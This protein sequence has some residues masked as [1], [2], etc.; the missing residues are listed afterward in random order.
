MSFKLCKYFSGDDSIE[1][2]KQLR[3][4]Q[5]KCGDYPKP[6]YFLDGF[7]YHYRPPTGHCDFFEKKEK[8]E[9]A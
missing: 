8:K 1:A 5:K 6:S 7:C 3:E 2:K 9:N 4:D